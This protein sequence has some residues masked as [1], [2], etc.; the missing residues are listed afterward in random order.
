MKITSELL[1]RCVASVIVLTFASSG[2]WLRAQ[3]IGGTGVV[4]ARRPD[5][6]VIV[7]RRAGGGGTTR[8]TVP[9]PGGGGSS[10]SSSQGGD[11]A[12]ESAAVNPQ[13]ED[14][15]ERGNTARDLSPP[16]YAEAEQAY[17]TA[18]DVDPKDGRAYAGLGNIYYDQ[19]RYADAE[20]YFR[21]AVELNKKDTVTPFY[22][23]YANNELGRYEEAERWARRATELRPNEYYGYYL[24]A[25][26]K[27]KRK[28]YKGAEIDYK[29]AIEL[30][31]AT[32]T[33]YYD[34]SSAL[35]LDGRYAE[36]AAVLPRG[37][38]SNA[39]D[40]PLLL[41]YALALQR[42]GQLEKAVEQY[43]QV[44]KIQPKMTGPHSS[45]GLV[46]YLLGDTAKARGEWQEAINLGNRRPLDTAGLAALD[47]RSD[48]ALP[49]LEQLTRTRPENEGGWLL[50]SDVRRALGDEEGAQAAYA[51]GVELVPEYAK[52]KR[53]ALTV[54]PKTAVSNGAS[55][56]A[57][58]GGDPKGR[59]RNGFT[60]L[61]KVASEGREAAVQ[62]LLAR[63]AEVNATD[64][65]GG[66]AL[67][68]AAGQGFADVVK[69]LLEKG[70]DA[71]AKDTR[72][73]TVLMY[74]S[75]Q[76]NPAIVQLLIDGKAD[77]NSK[78]KTGATA[79]KIAKAKSYGD[80]INLLK[81]AGAKD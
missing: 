3:D 63:G 34:L 69:A 13:L 12:A 58:G 68:Y 48:D 75:A 45:M 41:N 55:V 44:V 36:A 4:I 10:S 74:A 65:K 46:Y 50:L 56:G 6:P 54:K 25:L 49:Q 7:R 31:P 72:G 27:Y 33:L 15:L 38:A 57:D 73:Q 40:V 26:S 77:V 16:Q 18:V 61:M 32:G 19:K 23:A 81:K 28:D 39:E 37:V 21:K 60:D 8:P 71:N 35:M 17:K 42:S 30:S 62:S 51:R 70:A 2:V 22:L 78:S 9:R 29:K 20:P 79:I 67:M 1:S 52:L 80:I 59:D 64:N 11:N 43:Q 14:A 24:L 47:G 66:T 53:P 5:N 76:K